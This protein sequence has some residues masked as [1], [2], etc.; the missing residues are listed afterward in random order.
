[1]SGLEPLSTCD[2]SGVYDCPP[3]GSGCPSI[4]NSTAT[5][6]RH[7]AEY[8][9]YGLFGPPEYNLP[10][11][12]PCV[13][14]TPTLDVPPPDVLDLLKDCL[15]KRILEGIDSFENVANAV[16]TILKNPA[17]PEYER[18]L[19]SARFRLELTY[20]AL[21][22]FSASATARAT[23]LATE[24]FLEDLTDSRHDFMS[25][26][27]HLFGYI[28][29]YIEDYPNVEVGS[30]DNI[31]SKLASLRAAK[32]IACQPFDPKA[33]PDVNVEKFFADL[34]M[35]I[36]KLSH[37]V[38]KESPLELEIEFDE[39]TL[40]LEVS[41]N[42][43]GLNRVF[44]NFAMNAIR[45]GANR[46]KI[47]FTVSRD[48]VDISIQNNGPAIPDEHAPK[49]FV[50]PFS[51]NGDGSEK[52]SIG[53]SSGEGRGLISARRSLEHMGGEVLQTIP[54]IE[55]SKEG[56]ISGPVFRIRLRK[57]ENVC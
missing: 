36:R 38:A 21:K 26:V 17:A 25:Y 28:S 5:L 9:G 2:Y 50:V 47:S 43:T 37:D 11:T 1:M 24:D 30:M 6:N 10:D 54:F 53:P 4:D 39:H 32:K 18:A 42:T 57:S 12:N 15:L 46:M 22:G 51:T 27:D 3:S 8:V 31:N 52:P 13:N 16:I 45:A 41:I 48:H 7:V 55:A 19:V 49:L 14:M 20:N 33:C 56:D 40:G 23:K 35:I 29:A 44:R 34:K